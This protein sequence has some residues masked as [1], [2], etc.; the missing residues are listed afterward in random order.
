M[1][2]AILKYVGWW[3]YENNIESNALYFSMSQFIDKTNLLAYQ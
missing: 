2:Q 1:A 3:K